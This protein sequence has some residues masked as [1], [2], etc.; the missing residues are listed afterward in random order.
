MELVNWIAIGDVIKHHLI[1]KDYM[2]LRYKQQTPSQCTSF[3]P[4]MFCPN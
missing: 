4:A 3:S 2:A 1:T